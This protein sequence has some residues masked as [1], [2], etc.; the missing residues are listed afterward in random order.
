CTDVDYDT[1]MATLKKANGS[2]KTA[3]V[4]VLL[5]IDADTARKR[6]AKYDGA[7]RKVLD[8]EGKSLNL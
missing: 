1:G 3:L 7:L 8:E 5:N 4:M 2:V 6:L